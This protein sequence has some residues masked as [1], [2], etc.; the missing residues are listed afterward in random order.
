MTIAPLNKCN[1][2]YAKGYLIYPFMASTPDDHSFDPFPMNNIS[3]V[4]KLFHSLPEHHNAIHL[5]LFH[6]TITMYTLLDG[7]SL[8]STSQSIVH[9]S[10][11][12]VNVLLS[13]STAY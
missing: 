4:V 13:I 10:L 12:K 9:P 1:P 8:N 11:N 3:K 2:E 5:T 6:N 7:Q